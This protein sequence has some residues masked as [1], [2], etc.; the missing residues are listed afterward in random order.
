MPPVKKPRK[1]VN[2]PKS[3]YSAELSPSQLVLGIAILLVF[4][5]ACF[6]FGVLVGKFDPSLNDRV[7]RVADSEQTAKLTEEPV[8][9]SPSTSPPAK[10][11]PSK[12]STPPV[13]TETEPKKS[14]PPPAKPEIEE[15]KMT[16]T[17]APPTEE[18]AKPSQPSVSIPESAQVTATDLAPPE[19]DKPVAS[20]SAEPKP[21]TV[22]VPAGTPVTAEIV[23]AQA[24]TEAPSVQEPQEPVKPA[25][26]TS[27]KWS[28]QLAAFGSK[29]N[30]ETEKARLEKIMPYKLELYQS[31][32]GSLT[33]VQ[34]GRYAT[35]EEADVFQKQLM[36]RYNVKGF[37][38]ERK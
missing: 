16:V 35:K 15:V 2:S 24:T 32:D 25:P 37:S 1:P 6:L 38:V 33:M 19:P 23:T 12:T 4:G 26:V 34:A 21:P 10:A 17:K 27:G 22:D 29:K 8:V 9:S 20:V 7:V 5:L 14:D 28:V 13:K 3:Q 11:S 31:S 30:A 18:P 36:D